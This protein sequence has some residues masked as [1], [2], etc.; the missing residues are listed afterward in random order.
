MR[1]IFLCILFLLSVSA[2]SQQETLQ[3]TKNDTLEQIALLSDIIINGYLE[4][5]REWADEQL[6]PLLE[7]YFQNRSVEE[8]LFPDL[9]WLKTLFPKDSSFVILTWQFKINEN[10]YK[11]RGLVKN[12]TGI[13]RLNDQSVDFNFLLKTEKSIDQW[14]G[15]FAGLY[16]RV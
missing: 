9:P 15:A 14:P 7:D 12:D 13:F 10:Q 8:C 2:R 6:T 16:C 4:D 1:L 3:E 11:Y 5:T